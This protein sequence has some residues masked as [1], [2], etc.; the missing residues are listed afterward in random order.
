[1][2]RFHGALAAVTLGPVLLSGCGGW[3]NSTAGP[4]PTVATTPPASASAPPSASAA[5]SPQG[6]ETHGSPAPEPGSLVL[7]S[8]TGTSTSLTVAP[9]FLRALGR[10]GVHV[11]AVDGARTSASSAG[12]TTFTFPVTGGTATASP[13]GRDRFSGQVQHRG[14]LRVAGLGRSA[15]VDQLVIDGS[16][17]ELTGRVG[18]HRVPLLPLRTGPEVTVRDGTIMLDEGSAALEPAAQQA[19]TSALHLPTLPSVTLG[20]LRSTIT[21]G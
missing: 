10:L 20:T 2:K 8:V 7:T 5:P 15:T 1:M 9:A 19:L 14:G 16:S 18:G 6:T 4:R 21:G 12:T 17:D 11:F 13:A 3:P